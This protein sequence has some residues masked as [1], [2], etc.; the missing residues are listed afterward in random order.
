MR[1]PVGPHLHAPRL[2]GHHDLRRP[3]AVRAHDMGRR[4]RHPRHR[5]PHPRTPLP[6]GCTR[7]SSPTACTR[8][9]RTPRS[10]RSGLTSATRSW[11]RWTRL[12]ARPEL[13]ENP[14]TWRCSLRARVQALPR[15]CPPAVCPWLVVRRGHDVQL[16]K[17]LRG[18]WTSPPQA[19]ALIITPRHS[20]QG[21]ERQGTGRLGRTVRH[22]TS[23]HDRGR[24]QPITR[25][26]AQSAA[27]L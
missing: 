14:P 10:S 13:N 26:A 3:R 25:P 15:R 18:I 24:R 9:T 1:Q 27:A 17:R 11:L 6:G 23:Q 20:R 22:I 4:G 2:H 21:A 12:R 8:R 19:T 5:P 16:Q 7:S